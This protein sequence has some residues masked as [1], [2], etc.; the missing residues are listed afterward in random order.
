MPHR[1]DFGA[2]PHSRPRPGL[3]THLPAYLSAVA[4]YFSARFDLLALESKEA[5]LVWGVALG[6]AAAGLFV[7][8]VGYFFLVFALVFAVAQAFDSETAWIWITLGAALV[9]LLGAAGLVFLAYSRISRPLF[10][11]TLAELR[12]D[13]LWIQTLKETP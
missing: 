4:Q 1:L 11:E 13:T 3:S 10:A 8:V 2:M 12:K 7:I 6:L 9:H 5:A